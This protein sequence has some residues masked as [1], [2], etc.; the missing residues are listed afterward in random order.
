MVF[1]Y[2]NTL[3][4]CFR[5]EEVGRLTENMKRLILF[6]LENGQLFYFSE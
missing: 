4:Q 3:E 2:E 1:S 5:R 6:F